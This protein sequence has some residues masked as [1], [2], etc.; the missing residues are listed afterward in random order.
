M[1]ESICPLCGNPLA[2]G[3]V[4]ECRTGLMLHEA[5]ELVHKYRGTPDAELDM[6][7]AGFKLGYKKGQA[8]AETGTTMTQEGVDT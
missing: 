5:L 8:S 2:P 3:E 7:W 4:C 6:V 1:E